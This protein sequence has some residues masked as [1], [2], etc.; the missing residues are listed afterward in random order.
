M[1]DGDATASRER[2][3]CCCGSDGVREGSAERPHY[4]A[5]RLWRWS[6]LRRY[7]R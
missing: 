3:R 2:W 6:D 4:A 1:G 7:W 5:P